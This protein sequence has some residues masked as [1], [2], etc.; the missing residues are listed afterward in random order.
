MVGEEDLVMVRAVEVVVLVTVNLSGG[1]E[2]RGE[3]LVVMEVERVVVFGS[4]GG[5]DGVCRW[6]N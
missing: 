5:G 4:N 6:W 1:N 2:I 3:L